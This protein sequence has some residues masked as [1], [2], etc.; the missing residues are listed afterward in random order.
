MASGAASSL[1]ATIF[2]LLVAA[3][4]VEGP[5]TRWQADAARTR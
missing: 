4:L 2:D 1:M 3:A 5:A